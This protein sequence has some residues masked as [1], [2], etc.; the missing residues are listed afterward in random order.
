[1]F[2]HAQDGI[3][4]GWSDW[5]FDLLGALI[6]LCK[7]ENN[8]QKLVA[9]LHEFMGGSC[10]D[11]SAKYDRS[12]AEKL[13]LRIIEV[14]DGESA[15]EKYINAHL[16][17]SDFRKAA[18]ETAIE[19][20]QLDDALKMCFDG[21][22]QDAE[23]C[24]LISDWK[25]YRYTIYEEQGNVP[26]LKKLSE[27]FALDGEFEYYRKLKKLYSK[28]D[29]VTELER[30]LPILKKM[31]RNDIYVKALIDEGLIDALAEYCKE[32]PSSIVNL[33]PHLIPKHM[34]T[35]DKIFEDYILYCADR[36]SSRSAYHSVCEIIRTYKKACGGEPANKMVK[37]LLEKY[38]RRPAFK[39]ELGKIR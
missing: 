37:I 7:F 19:R 22:A 8:R 39:D 27:E 38:P 20:S 1:V 24:G 15:T 6:P 29:W 32:N 17:N 16:H 9:Y 28:A 14:F 31:R 21:E 2:E 11:W 13:E 30:L 33:Y 35:V 5:S 3:Y 12:R 25:H 36:A 23:Y 18:I 34:K 26:E 10:E 4:D